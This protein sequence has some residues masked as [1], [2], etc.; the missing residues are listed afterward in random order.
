MSGLINN[1]VRQEVNSVKRYLPFLVLLILYCLVTTGCYT[2]TVA[3]GWSNPKIVA[4]AVAKFASAP[5]VLLDDSGNFHLSWL[6]TTDDKSYTLYYLKV[7]DTNW[8]LPEKVC[9]LPDR[10]Y[11]YSMVLDKTNIPHFIWST[12]QAIFYVKLEEGMWIT[13]LVTSFPWK[14]EVPYCTLGIDQNNKLHLIYCI[15]G[16]KFR[17]RLYYT[18]SS[19]GINWTKPLKYLTGITWKK[20]ILSRDKF[21][22]IGYD[23]QGLDDSKKRYSYYTTLS[24]EGV[25]SKTVSFPFYDIK[26]ICIDN[27]GDP[28][29][30]WQD[31]KN[32]VYSHLEKGKWVKP[33]GLKHS[34]PYLIAEFFT[35]E[36]NAYLTTVQMKLDRNNNPHIL[37]H[38][39][40]YLNNWLA[41]RDG[42]VYY[43]F[44]DGEKWL[45][46]WQIIKTSE[47]TAPTMIID[48][49]NVIHIFW[50]DRSPDK[51]KKTAL[52]YSSYAIKSNE[53]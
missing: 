18:T 47:A 34:L 4:K 25:L 40:L 52:Y 11:N 42:R 7:K 19:D 16:Y 5:K 24:T 10:D 23:S 31:G 17:H 35:D 12:Y 50:I 48:K 33:I 53:P 15:K 28:H 29:I 9:I 36:G 1:I 20:A 37:W 2:V 27:N 6:E 45:D 8:G 30:L 44:F 32:F 46:R 38:L 26:D 21:H 14:S 22:L 49:H 41:P 51:D 39:H 43:T 3:R 13:S